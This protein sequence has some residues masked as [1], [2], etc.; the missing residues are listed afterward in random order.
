MDLIRRACT[1]GL[2][3][4]C[5]LP[6]GALACDPDRRDSARLPARAKPAA[7]QGAPAAAP[8]DAPAQE[9]VLDEARGGSDTLAT[10]TRLHGVVGGNVATNVNTGANIIQASS[11]ANASGIP[12]VIQNSGANVLIQNATVINLQFK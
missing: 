1:V 11:F 3:L 10:D 12:I 6:V 4:M 7:L 5:A 2:A 9:A 8:F